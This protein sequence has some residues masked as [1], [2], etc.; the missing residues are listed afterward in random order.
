MPEC[1]IILPIV[2][3]LGL[4]AVVEG[5][6]TVART[7]LQQ[8]GGLVREVT[9]QEWAARILA[10]V[11]VFLAGYAD[12]K[13]L[14]SRGLACMSWLIAVM[15]ASFCVAYLPLTAPIGIIAGCVVF[16]CG[17]VALVVF[18]RRRPRQ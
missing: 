11:V 10:L 4:G 13:I 1:G 5:H 3:G 2:L 18:Y 9:M 7:L 15:I 8:G 16:L 12:L 6:P 14:K 17:V